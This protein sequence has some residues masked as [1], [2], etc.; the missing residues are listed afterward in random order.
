M[1]PAIDLNLIKTFLTVLEEQ[2]LKPAAERLNKTPAAISVQIKKLESLLGKRVLERNN[3]G[4]VLTSAGETLRRKGRVLMQLNYE[5]LGDFSG[6]ELSG[7]LNFGA[8][9][10]YA[11]TLLNKLLPIFQQEFP[12]VAPSI[13]LEPSRILRPRV[14]SGSLDMAILACEPNHEEGHALWTEEVTWYG[15][16]MEADGKIR[17]GVLS[18]NCILR[19]RALEKLR[20]A[21]CGFNLVLEAATVASLKD[22]VEAGFCQAFLP[23]SLEGQLKRSEAFSDS[24]P[25]R[26][27]FSLVGND[28]FKQ[29]DMSSIADQF[30]HSLEV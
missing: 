22:A 13:S 19:D 18:T 16:V 24:P 7:P 27:T 15:N 4:I 26:L 30:R 20:E 2:G 21:N 23:A 11:P 12:H 28:R 25:L 9:T 3:Q 6:S 1:K 17:A 10:D 29:N 14:Q 8:P 5:L